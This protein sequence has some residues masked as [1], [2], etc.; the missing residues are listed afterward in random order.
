MR[1]DF[2]TP[3]NTPHLHALAE[4]GTFF[5]NNHS[6]FLTTTEVNAAV[7]A[8][9]AFSQRSGVIANREY[10]PAI[11]LV[12]PVGTE[13]A[14][15]I[16][17]GDAL[18]NGAYLH[19]MTV[20]EI[21]QKAGFRTVVAGAKPVALLH[22]RNHDRSAT[23]GSVILFYGRTYPETFTQVLT[24]AL[25][26][27]PPYP[28]IEYL[29][30]VAPN[31][32]QNA[33]TTRALVEHLWKNDVPRY[34]VLW[35]GDPD[36]SQ[37]LTA[38]GHP[39]ALAAIRDSDTH[40]GIALA[41]LKEKNLL[42]KT[43]VFV[44][45]DHGFSTVERVADPIAH[46]KK[47]GVTVVREFKQTPA[48]GEVIMSN[49]G[50]SSV[51]YVIDRDPAVVQKLVT[52]LQESDFA[53]PIFTRKAL[54]GTFPLETVHLASPQSPD[55][56]FSFRWRDAPSR[57]GVP[58]LI[59]A[60]GRRAPFGTHGTLSKYDV[61]NTLVA[62]GPDI[63]SGFKNELPT[64]NIDVVPTILHLLGLKHPDG[65]DGRILTE[66]LAGAEVPS[67]NPSTN[68]IEARQASWHQWI[69]TTTYQGKTYFDQ[70]NAENG[71]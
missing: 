14:D 28:V 23:H 44:V 61:H 53:G 37:H 71:Q 6:S 63:R 48:P 46:F 4:R 69:Q 43:D 24:A 10:R 21:V 33:W 59:V 35:L 45:S 11:D 3:E 29:D 18:E 19:T 68:R 55:I 51:L 50:G 41:A 47:G 38:P 36:F 62:A 54:P 25:G 20:A 2:I 64:G 8:T 65:T 17:I 5:A 49:V 66:S 31:T 13:A 27:F 52:L 32:A 22:D 56:V 30:D 34:S 60:E 1:P 58:G 9:G 39:V 40:L 16:R 57:L 42:E 67:E 70:G 26:K 7:L 12:K 15:T